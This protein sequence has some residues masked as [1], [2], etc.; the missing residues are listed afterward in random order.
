MGIISRKEGEFEI[1]SDLEG[2]P[3]IFW[4]KNWDW[5]VVGHVGGG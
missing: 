3:V 5:S 4:R 2:F 1:V